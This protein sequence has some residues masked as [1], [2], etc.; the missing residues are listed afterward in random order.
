M[1]GNHS[2]SSSFTQITSS[3]T[4]VCCMFRR[5][6][7]CFAWG[8]G[9]LWVHGL[10][11]GNLQGMKELENTPCLAAGLCAWVLSFCRSWDQFYRVFAWKSQAAR[12]LRT[13]CRTTSYSKR[14]F[15]QNAAPVPLFIE[16]SH[17]IFSTGHLPK[18][19]MAFGLSRVLP[20]LV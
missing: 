5:V 2:A 11:D 17:G 6:L 18:A 7:S 13:V 10:A 20:W 19:H 12:P 1:F 14:Q 16:T 9:S 15:G 3:W 4:S 8:A